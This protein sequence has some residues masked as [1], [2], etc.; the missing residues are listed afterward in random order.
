MSANAAPMPPV[1]QREA[2]GFESIK[3][4]PLSE[5][6]VRLLLHVERV[7]PLD[8]V[9]ERFPHVVNRLALVWKRPAHADRYFDELLTD[10]RGGRMGF[11]L[12][13]VMQLTDLHAYY[14]SNGPAAEVSAWE[15]HA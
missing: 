10:R 13:V 12:G 15:A 14:R 9:A 7:A 8:K 3:R 2:M 5:E 4:E 1:F 6:A 11:P